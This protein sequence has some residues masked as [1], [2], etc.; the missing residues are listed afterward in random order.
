[1]KIVSYKFKGG[2]L[3]LE[4]LAAIVVICAAAFLAR[5]GGAG[6]AAG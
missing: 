5:A 4:I 6:K 2:I 3:M 1:M